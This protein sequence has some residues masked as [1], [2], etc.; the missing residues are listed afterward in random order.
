MYPEPIDMCL[1]CDGDPPLRSKVLLSRTAQATLF[2]L[3]EL[4]PME[5]P[6]PFKQWFPQI[7]NF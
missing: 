2:G 5:R 6:P 7:S 3:K 1:V 4:A